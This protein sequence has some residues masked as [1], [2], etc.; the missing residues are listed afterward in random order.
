IFSGLT[1]GLALALSLGPSFF[2][3]IQTSTKRGF[4]PAFWLAFGIFLSDIL[5]VFLAYFGVA[6][7]F[8]NPQNKLYIGLAGG[9]VLMMFGFFSVFQFRAKVAEEKELGAQDLA[10]KAVSMPLYVTKG[11]FLNLLNPVVIGLWMACVVTVSSNKDY[12]FIHIL[13]FFIV[14]L[15]TV[16]LT[17]VLKAYSANKISK[18]LSEKVLRIVSII[19]GIILM[20]SGVIMI[21]RV[22]V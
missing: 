4:R 6:Q 21:Y 20:V 11:F 3:L 10:V 2:A 5:C 18:F 9:T 16:F 1:L 22:F 17:D 19:A 12:T 7:F 13:L 15:T 8:D 14:S